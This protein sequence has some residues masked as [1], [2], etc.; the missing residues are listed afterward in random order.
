MVMP[1]MQFRRPSIIA[2]LIYP[3][4]SQLNIMLF[5]QDWRLIKKTPGPSLEKIGL[6]LESTNRAQRSSYKNDKGPI[7]SKYD[8]EQAWLIE[9]NYMTEK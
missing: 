2:C 1:K 8:P 7:F 5:E 4:R 9:E 3:K 6:R